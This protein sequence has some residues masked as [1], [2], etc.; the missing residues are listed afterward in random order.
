METGKFEKIFLGI[1]EEYGT[2]LVRWAQ[3]RLLHLDVA[4]DFCHDTMV[5]LYKTIIK[6]HLDGQ[7]IDNIESYLWRIAN[8]LLCEYKQKEQRGID[9]RLDI[10][11]KIAP[12]L[13]YA[14]DTDPNLAEVV[15]KIRKKI[16]TL[17]FLHREAT[18]QHYIE[19]KSIKDIA[20]QLN[21]SET[22]VQKL[23]FESRDILRND[24]KLPSPN[25][26]GYYRPG[27]MKIVYSGIC[28]DNPD[29]IQINNNLCKQ[30][31]CIA[32]Y[33]T[34]LTIDEIASTL[35][36]PK[37]Y[38]EF[39]IAWLVD[40]GYMQKQGKKYY[41]TFMILDKA[42]EIKMFNIFLKHKKKCI[43]KMIKGLMTREKEIKAINFC[44][45]HKSMNELLWFLTY[46]LI[47]KISSILFKE[48]FAFSTDHL[49]RKDG[50]HYHPIGINSSIS[51]N[52]L[53]TLLKEKYIEILSWKCLG[54]YMFQDNSNIYT[55]FATHSAKENFPRKFSY[56]SL[57]PNFTD[58]MNLLLD[59]TKPDFV[60]DTL[61]EYE[62][63]LLN[64]LIDI[65]YVYI[66]KTSKKVIPNICIFTENQRNQLDDIFLEIYYEMESELAVLHE[67]LLLFSKSILP[68]HL[69]HL[70]PFATFVCF[71]FLKKAAL[72]FAYCDDILY[73]PK[74]DIE[75]SY[76]SVSI[77]DVGDI[78]PKYR[79]YKMILRGMNYENE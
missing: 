26:D 60:I 40:R 79:N 49:I 61:S 25:T 68:K 24:K 19:K 15:E 10:H 9:I 63:T 72:G 18:I 16:L 33:K 64:L 30:N 44:G 59:T 51:T 7:K 8:S 73:K 67:N 58:S 37:P 39:D 62:R 75:C 43:D 13:E 50:G 11:E 54:T 48:L 53:P 41:S 66:D 46:S 35:L 36:L 52:D 65:E 14:A 76:L 42:I 27:N 5:R 12:V 34:P 3:K 45:N 55:W 6:K 47:D 57:I 17:N 77:T 2:V 21:I 28:T 69:S 29:F 4:E 38:L 71:T 22:K 78:P 32:C 56:K 20:L 70:A 74:T 31:I 1:Y 23:L